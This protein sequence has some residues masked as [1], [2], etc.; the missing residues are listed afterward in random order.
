MSDKTVAP[1]ACEFFM[2]ACKIEETTNGSRRSACS[3]TRQEV[4]VLAQRRI[5]PNGEIDE[6]KRATQDGKNE[7]QREAYAQAQEDVELP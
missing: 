4:K 5:S 2:Y 3:K 6:S 7:A 1:F